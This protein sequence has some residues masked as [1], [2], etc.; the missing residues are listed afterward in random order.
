MADFFVLIKSLVGQ[1]KGLVVEEMRPEGFLIRTDIEPIERIFVSPATSDTVLFW[2]P[3]EMLFFRTKREIPS[4]LPDFLE[5]RTKDKLAKWTLNDTGDG[6]IYNLEYIARMNDLT[7]KNFEKICFSTVSEKISLMFW[8]ATMT[9]VI[10]HKPLTE[11]NPDPVDFQIGL[12]KSP[13]GSQ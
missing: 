10:H 12:P 2:L 5:K 11:L 3:E 8:V 7:P 9:K 1:V 13:K 4:W 6:F